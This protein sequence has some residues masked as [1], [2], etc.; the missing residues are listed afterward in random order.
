[1]SARKSGCASGTVLTRLHLKPSETRFRK[2]RRFFLRVKFSLVCRA[3]LRS[4]EEIE[5]IERLE[6]T[7]TSVCKRS[8]ES[9]HERSV[10]LSRN[11]SVSRK[12][13]VRRDCFPWMQRTLKE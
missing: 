8:P 2:D 6:T 4:A 10:E 9:S 12:V 1:M 7:L 11:P 5:M 13:A 3:V